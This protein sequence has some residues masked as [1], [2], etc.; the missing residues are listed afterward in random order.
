MKK[1]K[2]P[3]DPPF[4]FSEERYTYGPEGERVLVIETQRRGFLRDEVFRMVPP[5]P[6][7]PDSRRALSVLCHMLRATNPR[8]RCLRSCQ[9]EMLQ[10]PSRS[11]TVIGTAP[12][13]ARY[14]T[15]RFL[16]GDFASMA[17]TD[18]VR[19]SC[20]GCRA[21]AR[22]PRSSSRIPKRRRAGRPWR[23]RPMPCYVEGRGCSNLWA[24]FGADRWSSFARKKLELNTKSP[25]RWSKPT[26]R[27]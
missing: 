26:R 27:P 20:R 21:S 9:H 5:Q 12:H 1:G 3:D 15:A 7:K 23:V 8:R 18:R 19:T 16:S 24:A 4:R 25:L 14:S 10:T 13:A 22:T 17:A 11:M 6:F 2:N